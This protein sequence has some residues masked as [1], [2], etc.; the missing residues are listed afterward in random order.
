MLRKLAVVALCLAVPAGA[1]AHLCND[2]FAQASDNLAVKVDVRDGQLR[3]GETASFRVYLLNTMDRDIDGIAL[4]IT[5]EQFDAEVKP[6]PEW[7]TYPALN[8]CAKWR[9]SVKGD[10]KKEYFEVTLKRKAGVPD[11]KYQIG[12]TLFEPGKKDRVFRT[13]SLDD[14]TAVCELP[15]AAGIKI[16]GEAPEAEWGKSALCTDFTAY[17]K[18]QKLGK[19]AAFESQP[20]KEQPRF[21]LAADAENLYCLLQFPAV[22]GAE[23]AGDDVALYVAAGA[24]AKPVVLTFD[25]LTGKVSGEKGSEGVEVKAGADKSIL[26]CRIPLELLGLKGAKGFCANFTRTVT[27]KDVE[28]KEQKSVSYWR[29]NAPA[30][31]DPIVYGQ[32]RI[33]Q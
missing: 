8:T 6:S 16:D 31:L 29:G 19:F 23:A 4:G 2:V 11:G 24:D 18:V 15:K 27:A 12:L 9:K 20:A 25:R 30:L 14:A 13:V 26:E 33:A 1:L 7:K 10:G 17:V 21:R 3:I 22:A 32:F 5:S 28:G